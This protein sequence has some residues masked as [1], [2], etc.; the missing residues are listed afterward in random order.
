MLLCFGYSAGRTY[1]RMSQCEVL[2]IAVNSPASTTHF[3]QPQSNFEALKEEN[4]LRG[5][6]NYK[7]LKSKLCYH[8]AIINTYVVIYSHSIRMEQTKYSYSFYMNILCMHREIQVCKTTKMNCNV[9][10]NDEQVN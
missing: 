3:H 6:I 9:N 8:A 5:T 7:H 2:V 10:Q 1:A 4:S